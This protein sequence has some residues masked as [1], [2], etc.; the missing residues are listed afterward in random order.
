MATRSLSMTPA[1]ILT[2]QNELR[3]TGK[4][5][6]IGRMQKIAIGPAEGYTPPAADPVIRKF[7]RLIDLR[8]RFLPIA[9]AL[10]DRGML[11]VTAPLTDLEGRVQLPDVPDP[12]WT[13]GAWTKG[14]S[15]GREITEA[16]AEA[17]IKTAEEAGNFREAARWRAALSTVR[18]GSKVLMPSDRP[19][20]KDKQRMVHQR[21]EDRTNEI[22][23][24]TNFLVFSPV[25]RV[26]F[27]PELDKR[28]VADA[29]VITFGFNPTDRTNASLL[30]HRFTG[31]THFYGGLYDISGPAGGGEDL[32]FGFGVETG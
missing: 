24:G 31:E 12:D 16:E 25:L 22:L 4:Y 27:Q 6:P 11:L 26:M 10:P 32:F 21:L 13:P 17:A 14:E 5:L 9:Q 28:L 20:S 3:R 30:V 18:N 29:W 7:G 2:L 15:E 23:Q 8:D 19:L 1:D